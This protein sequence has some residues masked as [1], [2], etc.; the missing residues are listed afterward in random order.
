ME[1]YTTEMVMAVGDFMLIT[2]LST[3]IRRLNSEKQR[4]ETKQ[5]VQFKLED[6]MFLCQDDKGH[7][8]QLPINA[9]DEEIFSADGATFKPG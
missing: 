4:N 3:T 6:I 9:P 5:K 8:R 7:L 2:F 1:K